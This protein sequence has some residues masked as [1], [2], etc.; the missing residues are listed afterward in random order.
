MRRSARLSACVAAATLVAGACVG[1]AEA[2]PA[3]A[4]SLIRLRGDVVPKLVSYTDLGASAQTERIQVDVSIAR[5]NPAAEQAAFAAMYTPGSP[6]F[7]HFLTPAQF[8]AQYGV[9]QATFEAVRAFATAHGLTVANATGSRELIVLDGTVAQVQQ[10]FGVTL[11][12]YR[13]DGKTFYANTR[14]PLVPA[15]L[16]ITGVIGLNNKLGSHLFHNGPD[17][18]MPSNAT[19]RRDA[20]SGHLRGRH[21]HGAHHPA[22]PVGHLRAAGRFGRQPDRQPHRRL[23]PGPGDGGLRRGPDRSR[24]R[25]PAH[26]RAAARPAAPAR[27]CRARRRCTASPTTT[28]AARS[29]GISTPRPRPAC[30]RTR[31]SEVLY[32]GHDLSDQS[33][34]NVFNTWAD[35]PNGPLQA[36]ASYGE[37]EENPLGDVAGIDRRGVLGRRDV[38]ACQRGGAAARPTMEGRTLFSS[39]GDTGSSCPVVP[40]ATLNGVDQRGRAPSTT[41]PP[42][43]RTPSASA[44]RWSTPARR[45]APDASRALEYTWTYTGGG[46][47]FVCS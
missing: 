26:L 7:H 4:T 30:R 22:G 19:S 5:P 33:V 11:H 31:S 47:S 21:V 28:T 40:A 37:C 3:G 9:A 27:R 2:A 12:D 41:T 43:V 20:G 10:T 46:T 14:G 18:P 38:H 15:G 17:N 32:F 8:D 16:P 13:G 35:D 25:E 45:R 23:R 29:S 39:T 1:L 24:H 34:L 44:G 6:T 42:R 36:N